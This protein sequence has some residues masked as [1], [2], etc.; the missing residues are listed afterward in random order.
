MSSSRNAPEWFGGGAKA[1]KRSDT[2]TSKSTSRSSTNGSKRSQ[3]RRGGMGDSSSTNERRKKPSHKRKKSR[4]LIPEAYDLSQDGISSLRD[5][6]SA[7]VAPLESTHRRSSSNSSREKNERKQPSKSAQPIRRQ[8]FV[9]RIFGFSSSNNN[10]NSSPSKQRLLAN[11]DK[12]HERNSSFG[13]VQSDPAESPRKYSDGTSATSATSNAHRRTHS[14][15]TDNSHLTM[16]RSSFQNSIL[17]QSPQPPPPP[18]TGPKSQNLPVSSRI[19]QTISRNPLF[20]YNPDDHSIGATPHFDNVSAYVRAPPM[21]P[22][23]DYSG[24]ESDDPLVYSEDESTSAQPI[25]SYPLQFNRAHNNNFPYPGA[26]GQF[27]NQ[28]SQQMMEHHQM[29]ALA[30][31]RQGQVH[32]KQPQLSYPNTNYGSLN[33]QALYSSQIPPPRSKTPPANEFYLSEDETLLSESSKSLNSRGSFNRKQGFLYAQATNALVEKSIPEEDEKHESSPLLATKISSNG[34]NG[35]SVR[36]NNSNGG[37]NGSGSSNNSNNRNV[38]IAA[39]PALEIGSSH[40]SGSSSNRSPKPLQSPPSRRASPPPPVKSVSI[41]HSRTVSN[42]TST[43]ASNS[44]NYSPHSILRMAHQP[45]SIPQPPNQLSRRERKRLIRKLEIADSKED[46]IQSI[47]RNGHTDALDWSQHVSQ[48]VRGLNRP[49]GF[50][51][52]E[53]Q[54]MHDV[55]IAFIF[56]AQMCTVLYLG[57]LLS[58]ETVMDSFKFSPFESGNSGQS[59]L[60]NGG[61]YSPDY[62]YPIDPF[63]TGTTTP[64]DRGSTLSN[65]AKDIHVDYTNALQLACITALYATSLSALFIGMMMILGKALIPTVLCLTVIVCIAFGTIGIALNPYSCIPIIGI[66]LLAV[67][68]GYSIVVWDR[69]PFAATNLDTALC[70]VKCSADVLFVGLAMMI[71]AFF[72]T[73]GWSIALLGIYDHYLDKIAAEND[74]SNSVTVTGLCVYAGMFISYFWTLNVMK[75]RNMDLIT[76]LQSYELF[77]IYLNLQNIIHVTVA[78]VVATWWTDPDSMTNCCNKVLRTEFIVSLTSSF[79][80]ICLGSLVAPTLEVLRY[81]L[82]MCCNSYSNQPQTLGSSSTNDN[83]KMGE[84]SVYSDPLNLAQLPVPKSQIDGAIKYFNDFGFTYMGIYRECFHTSSRKATEVFQTREWVGVVSDKLIDTILCFISFAVTLGSGCFGIVVEEFDGYSFTNFQKPT[85]T[86]FFIGCAIGWVVSSVCLKVV[87]S[88][89]STVLVC[90]SLAPW[91]FHVNHPVLSR[92]MRTSWGGIWLDEYDW[93]NSGES[94]TDP[95]GDTLV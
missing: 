33:G 38:R 54:K 23:A 68:L 73:I 28:E 78:G 32:M 55:V 43:T 22:F 36:S 93:L 74:H 72:W 6:N 70:G 4:E 61:V 27:Q 88:S 26:Y 92:D 40:S 95:R 19:T 80:S 3:L 5:Q 37:G 20:Q 85:S 79:G 34:N 51:P 15:P 91:K 14:D 48:Q 76:E 90:F 44:V 45:H 24:T 77:L 89:V 30:P 67:S 17:R 29:M 86:A 52:H 62:D 9:E 60:G 47:L 82:V 64:G 66:I 65:W 18:D 50:F 56:I 57:W 35:T 7:R 53:K 12:H 16:A 39:V 87:S 31:N 42:G 69:I 13:S 59:P 84:Q 11:T 71:C 83:G 58:S 1:A 41:Q 75:V 10:D 8:S 94:G 2:G 81:A 46:K 49:A 25:K 21:A 63:S